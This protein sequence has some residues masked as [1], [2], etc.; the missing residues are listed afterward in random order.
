MAM[1]YWFSD[2]AG[3]DVVKGG[4]DNGTPIPTMLIRWI[5]SQ[6]PRLI[7]YGG[8]VYKEGKPEE[9]DEF[10]KQM[11]SDVSLMCE[12]PG[13]HDW[14]DAGDVAGKGRIPRGY[15]KFWSSHPQSKQP[16][17]TTKLGAARYDHVIDVDE[18]RLIFVDTGDY[19]K[20]PWP[21]GD[22]TRKAWLKNVLKPG[23]SN[24]LIAHH[25]RISCGNHGHNSKLDELWKAVFEESGPRVAFTLAGH[26]HN[27]NMYGPRSRNDPEEE[28]VPFAQGIHVFVNGAGGDGHYH[29]G[30]DILGFLPGKKG[31]LFSD[32]DNFCVT[33][34]N[35]IDARSADVDVVS[36]GKEA[37][38]APIVVPESLVRIRL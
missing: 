11:D 12:L 18:W 32:D 14:K 7:V 36:F 5:R 17:D 22:Q 10:F 38:T 9:F 23:R 30:S 31:D 3:V 37:K 20:N 27:V 6:S 28:S 26:D 25:S 2:G 24:I 29:C 4:P 1:V 19:R 35:L 13:N 33:R 8:D 34:I 16:I 21:A 15:E